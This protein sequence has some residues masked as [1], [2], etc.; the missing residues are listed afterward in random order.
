MTQYRI[1]ALATSF[2]VG[3]ASAAS[4]ADST[5]Q[6]ISKVYTEGLGRAPDAA[7][8]SGLE[9]SYSKYGCSVATLSS[10]VSGVLN[11][12]EF[13]ANARLP[14]GSYDNDARILDL[15]R[16]ALNR[17]PSPPE[18]ANGL[19]QLQSQT[20]GQVV[21]SVLA[22]SNFSSLANTICSL[23][24]NGIGAYG[25]GGDQSLNLLQSGSGASFSGS[26][27]AQLNSA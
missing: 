13:D 21:A 11:S 17:D 20:W 22:S 6:F 10:T 9:Q 25:W 5:S 15:Y 3:S 26:T 24:S 1:L 14:N 16:A 27:A 4:A 12:S 7:S 8:F 18:L 2:I 23:N 19:T